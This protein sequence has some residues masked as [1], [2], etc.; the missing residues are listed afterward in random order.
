MTLGSLSSVALLPN[1][2]FSLRVP[3]QSFAVPA[4]ISDGAD[5][6]NAS[7]G[8]ARRFSFR[9]LLRRSPSPN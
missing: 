6:F 8:S 2:A 5:A 4:S 1:L 3:G 9:Q 7:N